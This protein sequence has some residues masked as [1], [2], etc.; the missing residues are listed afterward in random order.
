MNIGKV[1]VSTKGKPPETSTSLQA[2]TAFPLRKLISA[3]Y[4]MKYT[5]CGQQG[6]NDNSPLQS[7]VSQF[8]T[9]Y[10]ERRFCRLDTLTL[11]F[12]NSWNWSQGILQRTKFHCVHGFILK[13]PQLRNHISVQGPLSLLL[14]NLLE[15]LTHYL[16]FFL[17]FRHLPATF[18][19]H[20][21]GFRM[22]DLWN[23]SV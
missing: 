21:T 14:I 19:L 22:Y 20:W 17:H 4:C 16:A 8:V 9:K 13:F 6:G 7:Y 11:I 15:V 10:Q 3:C 1:W 12:S 18:D 2:P 23:W 5:P